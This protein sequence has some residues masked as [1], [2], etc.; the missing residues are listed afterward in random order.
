M[1]HIIIF[2]MII[3]ITT[4]DTPKAMYFGFSPPLEESATKCHQ[5]IKLNAD[6][7]L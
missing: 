4:A 7:N 2:A 3:I 6:F 5:E 1:A